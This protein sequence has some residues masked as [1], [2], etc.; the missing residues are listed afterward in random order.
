MPLYDYP[1]T[2]TVHTTFV[3]PEYQYWRYW[4]QLMRDSIIGEVEIKRKNETYLSRMQDMQPNEYK[5]Y[6]DRAVFFNMTARTLTG[7]MGTLFR[8][9]PVITG[10]PDTLDTS[11]I[12]K[13][14]Q[15]LMQFAKQV[16]RELISM[17]RYGV[18]LDMDQEGVRAPYFAG[19]L[20]EN[21]VDW[22][23]KEINGRWTIT[24]VILRELR[25]ARPILNPISLTP[26]G[27]KIKSVTADQT[28]TF[29]I[30][31]A[32]TR[33]A[34]RWIA[35]YRV[36]RLEDDPS[37]QDPHQKIYRQYYHVSD[38]GDASP[39]G[40]PYYMFEPTWRGQPFRHIPFVFFGPNDNTPDIEKSPLLDIA[41]LNH[42]H[43]KSYAQL[44]HG[45]Y[46]TALPVYYAPV[47]PGQERGSYSVGPSVVW[48]VEK[49]EK[50]GIIEFN[51]SGLKYLESACDKKED[52][53]AALGGRLVGV[54]RVSAGESANKLKVKE[55]NEQALLLNISHVVD[56]GMTQLLRMWAM[57]Q[58]MSPE[59]ASK[60]S[61]ETNKDFL[62]QAIGAREFRAIHMMYLDG[63]IPVDVLF[64]YMNRAELIP[65][66]MSLEQFKELLSD[67]EQ[68]PNAIN[69]LSRQR[70][71]PDAATEWEHEHVLTDPAV[72][73]VLG[74]DSQAPA[75]QQPLP[76]QTQG[77]PVTR[78]Q[79][80][81]APPPTPASSSSSETTGADGTKTKQAT[82]TAAAP[83]VPRAPRVPH[84]PVAKAPR[85]VSKPQTDSP[86][87]N[88]GT[89]A[90]DIGTQTPGLPKNKQQPGGAG[91]G[92]TAVPQAMDSGTTTI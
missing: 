29:S 40:T 6:L 38:R 69:V 16:G 80:L 64:D 53:I 34:R 82:K 85:D 25:L 45:R 47:P 65:D 32:V 28:A 15:T 17:G 77:A 10:I 78:E 72:V 4:W 59:D 92:L 14:N 81:P 8:R 24:E 9:N 39:E 13:E 12:S 66:W 90:N 5:D 84:K 23:I 58:D 83:K 50:P 74:Y 73:A 41:L 86:T 18:L 43:Y 57:W 1:A 3:H 21:I 71:A 31:S 27:R 63:L 60:I 79:T 20:A 49:G 89:Q 2:T 48:E 61:F 35:A 67:P 44:E 42:S 51:G 88:D 37:P 62:S 33:A 68:F 19:Y 87:L 11:N 70:G 22:T 7:L 55:Q 46:Y 26:A 91:S 54:E 52:Q 36:L 30:D 56:V 76:G 75:G